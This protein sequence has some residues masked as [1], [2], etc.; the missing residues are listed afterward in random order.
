[1]AEVTRIKFSQVRTQNVREFDLYVMRSSLFIKKIKFDDF[2]S[3]IDY[4]SNIDIFNDVIS[5]II[6][7]CKPSREAEASEA[8]L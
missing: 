6:N 1:M 5:L 3:D 7:Q 8:R 4:N 2:S